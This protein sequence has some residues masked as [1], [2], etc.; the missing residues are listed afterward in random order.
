MA[1]MTEIRRKERYHHGDLR[2][3]LVEAARRLIAEKGVDQFSVSEACRVANV[4]TAAPYNHFKNKEE[5]VLAVALDGLERENWMMRDALEA[6]PENGLD[7]IIAIGRV[8]VSFAQDEPG[9]FRLI[10]GSAPDQDA[11]AAMM[12]SGERNYDLVHT[13]VARYLNKTE[14]DE[15]VRRRALMLWTFVHGLS[16]LLIDNKV[17]LADPDLDIDGFLRAVG[18]RVM[19]DDTV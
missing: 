5:M 16:F 12:Q 18:E 6:A 15:D 1:Q 2:A 8:Y 17:G 11:R 10:A 14:I 7:R 13:E 19:R 9:V 4:S 3:Q